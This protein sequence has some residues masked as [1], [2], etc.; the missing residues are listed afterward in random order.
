MNVCLNKNFKPPESGCHFLQRVLMHPSFFG[1]AAHLYRPC[2]QPHLQCL[3]TTLWF[4]VVFL[5]SGTQF[6]FPAAV[7]HQFQ[8][9]V[10]YGTTFILGY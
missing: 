4:G 7:W 3:A 1:T 6:Q 9:E 8:Q 2:M 5:Y 10:L